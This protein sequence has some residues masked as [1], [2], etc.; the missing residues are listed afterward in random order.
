MVA[1]QRS[2]CKHCCGLGVVKA[3]TCDRGWAGWIEVADSSQP[4]TV[5]G[6]GWFVMWAQ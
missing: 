3:A 4:S 2:E 6:E 1:I 5:P